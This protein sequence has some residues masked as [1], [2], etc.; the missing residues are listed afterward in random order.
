MF[1]C[2]FGNSVVMKTLLILA[3]G[4][5]HDDF[6]YRTTSLYNKGISAVNYKGCSE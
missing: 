5:G 3:M 2:P 4:V 1:L 6:F